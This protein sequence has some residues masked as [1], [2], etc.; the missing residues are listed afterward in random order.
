MKKI[1]LFISLVVVSRNNFPFLEEQLSTI[2]QK[3]Y[4]L[5]ED[6]EVIVVDN[7]SEDESLNILQKLTRKNGIP[8]L[9]VFAL[10]K[11]VSEDIATWVGIENSLGDVVITFDPFKDDLSIISQMLELAVTGKEVVFAWNKSKKE[12]LTY[13]LAYSIYNLFFRGIAGV[14]LTTE[15]PKFRLITKKVV[16]YLLKFPNPAQQYRF[17]ASTAGFPKQTITYDYKV[18]EMERKSIKESFERGISLLVA[19]T[20]APMRIV[21][22]CS[23]F[24]A[25]ANIIYSVYVI[26]IALTKEDVAAGW[27]TLSLQQSGMFFL[28]SLVLFILGEYILH[29]ASL[30]SEGPQFH[31]AQEMTSATI[32]HREKLNVTT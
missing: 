16:N 1:E 17:L 29:M 7:A 27:V 25:F 2:E 24:G 20:K 14:N 3:L 28:I 13:S 26:Y 12:H 31:I 23:L 18:C 22:F 15:S 30:G 5:A 32:R 8:N 6:Y 21:T 19:T 4:Q 11:K 10:T 9:Q